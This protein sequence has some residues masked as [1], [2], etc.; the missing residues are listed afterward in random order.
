K[1]LN[2]ETDNDLKTAQ[3]HFDTLQELLW[4][5]HTHIRSPERRQKLRE[6]EDC[7]KTFI[8]KF[9]NIVIRIKARND[10]IIN[11]YING[12]TTEFL[13]Y[14]LVLQHR[15][16]A[17]VLFSECLAFLK[18]FIS[19]EADIGK[20]L[21]SYDTAFAEKIIATLDAVIEEMRAHPQMARE[22]YEIESFKDAF[23]GLA[24]VTLK[25]KEEIEGTI[26]PLAPRMV[27]L[28][29]EVTDSGWEEMTRS[30]TRIKQKVTMTRTILTIMGISGMVLGLLIGS[31]IA[32]L[33]F[34]DIT[35]RKVSEDHIRKLNA[36]LEQRVI[37][38]TSQLE[39]ANKELESFAYS[40]S[41]DLRTPLRSIDGFSLA[42]IED[43]GDVVPE[44][45]K[46][47]LKRVRAASQRM[48]QLIDDI[49]KLS[50]VSRHEINRTNVDVS[51]QAAEIIENLREIEPDR[52]VDVRIEQNIC[53][54]ADTHLLGVILN[55][56]I[57][58][59]W[60]YTGKRATARIEIGTLP[61][62]S[63]QAEKAPGKTIYYVKDNGAG[64]DMTYADK[65][66]GAFQRLHKADEFSGTGIGLA[67]VQRVITR[68]G[69]TIW[70]E[71]TV[72]DGA[73]FYFT[74]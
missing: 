2:K 25:M 55:N 24:A 38:R 23:E 57:G 7:A 44:E 16:G 20:F 71:S 3:R 12:H 37:E 22:V 69:G 62:E 50:R 31:Y 5:A 42:L 51:E 9:N 67:T 18:A 36:E 43:F 53:A 49:L 39:A 27:A 54:S 19:S 34:R 35:D 65:L 47:Y 72:D 66:F 74:L 10:N 60:K 26:I 30:R 61:K 56:L 59:S 6:I 45:G 52:H 17:S 32:A 41:H 33:V 1:Y 11:L 58:N 40:V 64:F 46:Q 4:E 29:T 48:A 14:E 73:T 13:L 70:A 68:H 21:L 15:A 63:P 28:S 8:S